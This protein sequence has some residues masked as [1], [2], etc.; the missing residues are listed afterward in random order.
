MIKIGETS[1]FPAFYCTKTLDEV[2]APCRVFNAKEA[3]DVVETQRALGIGS[4]ILFVM[5]IPDEHALDPAVMNTAIHEALKKASDACVT[6][7]HVTPFLLREIN[8]ITCGRSLEASE[9]RKLIKS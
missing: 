3:A 9:Y 2:K 4:G 8:E 7:K 1:D 5:P 6:G